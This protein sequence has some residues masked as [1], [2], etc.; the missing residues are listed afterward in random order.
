MV[1]LRGNTHMT[2]T[3]RGVGRGVRQKWDV[4]GRRVWRVSEC[5]G[6]PIFNFFITENWICAMTKPKHHILL[7]R[8]LPFDSNVRQW[9]QPL[10]IPLH[11]LWAKSNNKPHGQFKCD[12]TWFR[13]CLDFV[14]S[15][16]Q[17]GCC[18]IVCLRFQVVQ[19][20]QIDWKMNTKIWIIINDF[21]QLHMQE[22]KATKKQVMRLQLNQKK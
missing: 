7:T 9:S 22:F 4:I 17:C 15:H 21:V 16:I 19:V 11:C 6:R 3:L 20:K 14:R 1:L 13:F 2:S 12:V 18:S 8:N 10:M 5:F